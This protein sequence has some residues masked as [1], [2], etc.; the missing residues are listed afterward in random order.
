LVSASNY[1]DALHFVATRAV[2]VVRE[3]LAAPGRGELL[4]ETLLSAISPG[5]ELL[6]YRGEVPAGMPLD[7]TIDGLTEELRYPTKY[8]YST[9]GRVMAA[10]DDVDRAWL[11]R[12]VFSFHPHESRFLAAPEDLSPIPPG[13]EPDDAVLFPNVETAMTLV[14]D[15]R[16]LINERVAVI[17]QGVVGLLTTALLAQFP[18]ADLVTL[19]L[20]PP[21]RKLSRQLG[22]HR[23]VERIGADDLPEDGFDLT[24]ELSGSPAGLGEAIELT[25]F[26]GRVVIGSWYGVRRVE[27]DLGG[28][29]HRSRMRLISSQVST[30]DP[31][32]TG[33]W[34]FKRR[35]DATW[36][37][38]RRLRPSR[39]V[40]HRMGLGDAVEAYALLDRH[41]DQALQIIFTYGD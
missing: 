6:V 39:L 29:F 16:P 35:Q 25:G 41:P 3:P 7:A 1:R 13:I 34:S 24:Y 40:T 21:R 17:G 31:R 36:D 14:L 27:L 20:H 22:A 32:L 15:G 8:G 26:A 4:V 10:G 28:R 12:L 37:A 11:D 18:L 9:V 2:E 33:R 19:D 38:L 30:I 23:S 5:S